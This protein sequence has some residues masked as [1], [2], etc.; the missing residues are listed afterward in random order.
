MSGCA[1]SEQNKPKTFLSALEAVPLKSRA[2]KS[3]MRAFRAVCLAAIL[4]STVLASAQAPRPQLPKSFRFDFENNIIFL[5]VGINGQPPV[6]FILDTGASGN[7]LDSGLVQKMGLKTEGER[8][9]TGAG[10]GTVQIK[11]AKNVVFD[12]PGLSTPSESVYVIDLSGQPALMGR[13]VGGILGYDFFLPYVVEVDYPGE[14]V[15]LYDPATFKYSGGG[16]AVAFTL[17]KKTPHIPIK[18]N[19]PGR[20]AVE[21]QVLIDSGS[22]DAVDDDVMAQSSN[23]LEVVGGVGLG[24]EF[25]TTVGRAESVQIGRYTLKQPVGVSGG[26][27]LIGNEL[28]RRFHV[29]FDYSRQKLYLEPNAHLEDQLLVN[30]SGLDLRWS[31]DFKSFT[32]HDV[33]LQSPASEAG[34]K[35]G[36]LLVAIDGSPAA[37]FTMEQVG[38]LFTHAGKQYR[39]SLMRGSQPLEIV[40]KLR[41]RL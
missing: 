10:K 13:E 3:I 8:Q 40:I 4:V 5:K 31:P 9:G 35:N 16:E 1:R 33:A 23:K 28:L 14:L 27:A 6:W 24:Q 2:S 11:F 18:I 32:V 36:D 41:K 29:I 30:A 15:T 37:E 20:E 22:G 21:R 39:L 12:L 34:V 38:T 19:I 17:V 7:V 26:V 25:R